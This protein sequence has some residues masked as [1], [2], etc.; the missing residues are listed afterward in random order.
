MYSFDNAG[1]GKMDEIIA[2]D[3]G[4]PGEHRESASVHAVVHFEVLSLISPDLSHSG[5]ITTLRD[6]PEEP[7]SIAE[8]LPTNRIS[9]TGGGC[10]HG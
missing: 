10:T 3:G 6:G 4:I 8:I 1:D 5:E 7:G 2:R 9:I